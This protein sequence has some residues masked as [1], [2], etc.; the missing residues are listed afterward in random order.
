M[1]YYLISGERS[2]DL[3]AS[4]LIKQLKRFDEHA[5]F[6]GFGGEHMMEAGATVVVHYSKMAVMGFLEVLLNI[7][8]ISHY[9]SLCKADISASKPD[10]VILVD[11][12]GFNTKIAQYCKKQNI[13]V[14]YYIPPKVWA[15]YQ[16]RAIGLKE[17]TDRIFVI[18]PFEKAFFKKFGCEVDYVGNPVLDAVKAHVSDSQFRH[19]HNFAE[20][21][22]LVALLPGSRRQ[23][24][25]RIVP[26]LAAIAR[27][28]PQQQFAVAAVNNLDQSLYSDLRALPNVKFVFEDTYNLLQHA[29]AAIVTSGTATL[30]TA[31]FRVP[32]IVVYKANRLSYLLAAK[33]IKVDFI[34]LVNLIAG[35]E[36]VKELLQQEAT[37]ENV[38]I[39]L[40]RI[41]NEQAYRATMLGGYDQVIK[42]LDTG[43]A[44]EN[45]ASLMTK[46]LHDGVPQA[47]YFG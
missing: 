12:G 23:E 1:H 20:L 28:H 18:L 9:I 47:N 13:K 34:S 11:Y 46:Y 29:T 22:P 31:L 19:R 7:R 36:V 40:N 35:K 10:V 2:G 27:S 21:E 37:V 45:A 5:T 4:N 17:N 43:S 39:E 6:R 3:H 41:I 16:R 30:E 32:Q 8:K 25:Q 14:F 42:L 44:S 38:S 26:L 33:V 15:W 24:L